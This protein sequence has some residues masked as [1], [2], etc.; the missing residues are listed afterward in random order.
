MLNKNKTREYLMYLQSKT[1]L[2]ITLLGVF[3]LSNIAQAGFGIQPPYVKPNKP[4]FA[5]THYEQKITLLRSSA[6]A[7]MQAIVKVSAPEMASWIT[8]NK[9]DTFDLPKDQ[10][11]VT[12]IV[13]VDVPNDAEIGNYKGHL[14]IRIAPKEKSLNNGVAIALGA[15]VEID[16]TVTD[17]SFIDFIVRK[18]DI[19]SIEQ[20]EKPWN[21]KIFSWFFYRIKVVMKI[22][23]T[24][25]T[26]IAPSRVHI[27]VYDNAKKELLESHDDRRIE[28]IEAFKTKEVAAAFP[29]NLEPGEYWGRISIYKDS[30]IIQK[31]EIIFTVFAPGKALVPLRLGKWPYIMMMSLIIVLLIILWLLIKIKIWNHL[32][33]VL[34]II[35]WPLRYLYKL[36]RSFFKFLNLKFW[37]WM[38][39]K[40]SKYQND[41]KDES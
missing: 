4:I 11:R 1:I 9:G 21:W 12:M 39:T 38:H 24:G 5:G 28:K 41:D 35:T 15:R 20:L 25:N 27:D 33:L 29:T 37:R 19:P 22:E 8:V 18:V 6:D 2:L 3:M 16:L 13:M 26:K 34:M 14:N 40:A 30:D 32:W 17:E 23:N 7:D 31:N 10:L 36:I